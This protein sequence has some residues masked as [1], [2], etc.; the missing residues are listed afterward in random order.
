MGQ[1]S[2]TSMLIPAN[3]FFQMLW[4]SLKSAPGHLTRAEFKVD[5]LSLTEI[6]C[7]THL[8]ALGYQLPSGKQ[9]ASQ[10]P[11]W[12]ITG[13]NNTW[14]IAFVRTPKSDCSQAAFRT[15]SYNCVS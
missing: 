1:I 12:M 2:L 14:H 13:M 9:A 15:I 6:L 5:L 3:V 10:R 8:S 7:L 4:D 11:P